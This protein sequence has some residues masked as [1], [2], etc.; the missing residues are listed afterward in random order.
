LVSALLSEIS[1]EWATSKLY[2]N[3]TPN[4]PSSLS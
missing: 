4:Q 2:L 1:S 3:M